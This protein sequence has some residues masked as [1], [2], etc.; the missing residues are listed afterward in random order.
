M[1]SFAIKLSFST[2][3]TTI[4]VVTGLK[5]N[6]TVTSDSAVLCITEKDNLPPTL[7][8]KPL[9]LYAAPSLPCSLKVSVT[10]P[11]AWQQVNLTA[12]ITADS[13]MIFTPAPDIVGSTVNIVL[14]AT[15]NGT[16]PSSSQDS[17]LITVIADNQLPPPPVNVKITR[18]TDALVEICWD[19]NPLA[20]SYILY[21]KDTDKDSTWEAIVKPDTFHI[22]ST[23]KAYI[24]WV[25]AVN[26]FGASD[27][28]EMIY[29]VDTVNYA[30][31]VFFTDSFST[32]FESAA[33]HIIKLGVTKPASG[34]ITAWCTLRGDSALSNDFR[35]S[36]YIVK[37]TAGTSFGLCTLSVINDSL[38]ETAELFSV[39]LD[40]VSGGFI[41]SQQIHKISV[42]DDDTLFAVLYNRNGAESGNVPVDNNR[43]INNATAIV[44]GNTGNLAKTGFSFAG[45]RSSTDTTGKLYKPGDTLT[46]AVAGMRLF[47]Q[48]LVN[49][50]SLSYDGNSN[51]GGNPP[52]KQD[53]EYQSQI[54]IA[55]KP[56]DLEKTGFSFLGW[57][58]AN[59][60]SGDTLL[61]GDSIFMDTNHIVLHALWRTNAYTIKYNGNG[62]STGSV[63]DSD[64]VAF[65]TK[66]AIRGP[67]DLQKTGF[68]FT[69]WNTR[70]DGT[71]DTLQP[72]DSLSTGAADV[73]LYAMWKVNQYT[74][75][76]SGN[77]NSTG[78]VPDSDIVAF[79]TE[80]IIKGSG[81]LERTGFTFT[82]W[83]TRNDGT[84]DTLLPGDTITMDTSHIILHA[85]WRSNYYLIKYHG[86]GNNTGSVPDSEIVAYNTTV[87]V[88]SPGDLEKTGFTFTGWN[89]RNN[90][91]GDTLQPGGTFITGTADVTLYAMWKVN[92][93]SVKYNGN[94]ND[95]GNTPDSA[96]YDYGTNIKIRENTGNLKKAG[97]QFNGWNTAADGSGDSLAPGDSFQL[98]AADIILYAQW[99]L[100]PPVIISHPKDTSVRAGNRLTLM[101]QASGINLSYQWQ[102]NGT[103]IDGGT[104]ST[105]SVDTVTRYDS[106]AAYRCIISNAS[107]S[108]TSNSAVLNVIS[109]ASVSAGDYHTMI[110]MTDGTLWSTGNNAN[111]QLGNGDQLNDSIPGQIMSNVSSVSC[112]YYH[113]MILKN[114]G[115]LFGTG[116]NA[117]GQLGF[118]KTAVPKLNTPQLV[119]S[120]VSSVSTKYLYTMI[121]K[122]DGTLWGTGYNAS[123][124][125]GIGTKRDTFNLTLATTG[126]SSV[127][128]GMQ[129]TLAIKNGNLWAAGQNSSGQFCNG[130][131][132]DTS[133]FILV[134]SGVSSVA[135]GFTFTLILKNGYLYG[136]G[137]NPYGQL[138]IGSTLDTVPLTL[139]YSGVSSVSTGYHHSMII[140]NDGTL[141]AAGLNS[142]GRLG[143][144]GV[145]DEP[146]F[147]QI[148][149]D[150]SKVSAGYGHT[151][152]IK[153]DGTLWA[154]GLNSSGQLG[155]GTLRN[156]SKPELVKF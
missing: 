109:I 98:D 62:N 39:F 18:R 65:N 26:F 74:V 50:Y 10:N 89:T 78:S 133:S 94:G 15:D 58:T 28:S 86:N 13:F 12:E 105:Y 97:Y 91:T 148:M 67:G 118:N 2:P 93:Y 87:T 27:P 31:R 107:G 116:S 155:I 142:N 63:P 88:R 143:T 40:S 126:V 16:V 51:T 52:A 4:L 147:V 140:K 122:N 131:K 103:N 60:G 73:T 110:L 11:E 146:S 29:G 100:S 25:S 125:L 79:D 5:N 99:K 92:Q 8:I 80:V 141:Y 17:V 123:G 66:V 22:D 150:V 104:S 55:A 117:Y 130:T 23:G 139:I 115:T 76:Y 75:K 33:S 1:K 9:R 57:N 45:W 114:D 49:K 37:I 83:S 61:P 96:K 102:K 34:E 24:Y 32:A 138:G 43:Y 134:A 48:W 111:G 19:S 137:N 54:I 112:G 101:V 41:S 53:Y 136:A 119:A 129:H 127:C 77:G 151:M 44:M 156:V 120:G 153:K 132:K 121:L 3:C 56:A 95:A 128:A 36:V 124:Q 81:D 46:V 69:G 84:G 108:V 68:T 82:G 71:G 47:A 64:I 152:I 20:D 135:A 72:G 14:I 154:T 144:G 90:G 6:T 145:N 35:D 85:L 59:D 149:S 38:T 113:S 42:I 21:R 7:I 106:A 30:H 70:N